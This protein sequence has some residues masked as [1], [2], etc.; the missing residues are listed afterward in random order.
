MQIERN[1]MWMLWKQ[2]FSALQH[3]NMRAFL[4]P[5]QKQ[6]PSMAMMMMI[7]PAFPSSR[8]EKNIHAS[9]Q[10]SI[11]RLFLSSSLWFYIHKLFKY[12]HT[13]THTHRN[14]WENSILRKS[15]CFFRL[16]V[17]CVV[18]VPWH[19]KRDSFDGAGG[20]SWRCRLLSLSNAFI[21]G[22]FF[23][24][25]SVP[26]LWTLIC[27]LEKI[28]VHDKCRQQRMESKLRWLDNGCIGAYFMVNKTSNIGM[29]IRKLCNFGA[30]ACCWSSEMSLVR[31]SQLLSLSRCHRQ[32][33]LPAS[34]IISCKF[35]LETF[36][37]FSY[38]CRLLLQSMREGALPYRM[39][40]LSI[41]ILHFA[42]FIGN[43]ANYRRRI[44]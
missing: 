21:K 43:C 41:G 38:H 16:L 17:F 32:F 5:E 40:F 12:A 20:G 19:D 25:N 14:K 23:I 44:I 8:R 24:G 31:M 37:C 28:V 42:S 36:C 39:G 34:K 13:H 6:E 7:Q 22:I 1:L 29:N 35:R 27:Q 3:A 30:A 11:S 4:L 10:M 33:T 15:I 26:A 18:V 9:I 2:L